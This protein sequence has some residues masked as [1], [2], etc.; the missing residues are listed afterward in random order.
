M[1]IK[2]EAKANFLIGVIS[3]THGLLPSG[4][5]KAFK[6]ADLI[7]HAGDVGDEKVLDELSRIAPLVAVRGNMDFGKWAKKLPEEETIEIGSTRLYVLHNYDR[8][9][10]DPNHAGLRAIITGHTHRPDIYEKNGISFL[11]PGSATY[12]K[13]GNPASAGLIQIGDDTISI[14]LIK[15]KDRENF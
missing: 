8:L 5:A 6:N 2:F 13:F 14:K 15:F 3:D 4:V 1:T 7:I 10:I 11:N 9:G 12:P